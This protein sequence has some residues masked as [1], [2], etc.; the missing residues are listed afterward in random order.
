MASAGRQ[1]KLGS[2]CRYRVCP[3]GDSNTAMN[4]KRTLGRHEVVLDD[5]SEWYEAAYPRL[6]RT[7]AVTVGLSEAEDVAAE[8]FSRAFAAWSRNQLRSRDNWVFTVALNE[9]RRRGRW[10][11]RQ[12]DF[13]AGIRAQR[14]DQVSE[15]DLDLWRAV[16]RLPRRSREAIVLRYVADLTEPDIADVMGISTGTVSATLHQ[17]RSR[18]ADQIGESRNGLGVTRT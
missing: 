12:Q 13:L 1:R 10:A 4:D 5:F 17:A 15:S 16:A 2:D 14:P 7:L 6:V 9:V 11:R 18:L 3:T 8:T